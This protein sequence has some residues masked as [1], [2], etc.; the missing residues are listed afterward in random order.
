MFMR[1]DYHVTDW[2]KIRMPSIKEVFDYK[3]NRYHS[4]VSALTCIPSDMISELYAKGIDYR[5]LD[6]FEL[7]AMLFISLTAEDVGILL[8]D[9]NPSKCEVLKDPET[10]KLEIH[11]GEHVMDELVYKRMVRYLRRIHYISPKPRIATNDQTFEVLLEVDKMDK[12]KAARRKSK[13]QLFP[14]VSAMMAY[15]GFK[16]KR[17]ELDQVGLFEFYDTMQRSQ[18]IEN[19]LALL[20]GMYSGMVDSSKIDK[21]AYNWM[22]EIEPPSPSL[23]MNTKVS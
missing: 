6:D 1:E 22:R 16:Y 7:F 8:V 9:I 5:Y 21:N 15:P 4:M 17:T 2:L 13:S 23:G 14:I 3:E 20:R 11:F 10:G 12:R 19:S 18:I